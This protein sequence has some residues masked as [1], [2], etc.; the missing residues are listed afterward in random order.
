MSKKEYGYLYFP[1]VMLKDILERKQEALKEI[2][3]FNTKEYKTPKG[4][5][6]CSLHPTIYNSFV[7]ESKKESDWVELI[8]FLAIRSILGS[9]EHKYVFTN[10][11]HILSRMLGFDSYTSLASK[12]N[13]LTDKQKQLIKR[14][15]KPNQYEI[16]THKMKRL[17][18][19]LELKWRVLTYS[20]FSRGLFISLEGR[21]T[22]EELS[23]AC[24]NRRE[25]NKIKEL[26]QRKKE[27]YSAYKNT[28]NPELRNNEFE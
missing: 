23:A 6:S 26:Q 20:R 15:T 7:N 21:A 28:I 1:A 9:K 5:S 13:D 11:K 10:N 19:R 8:A 2:K 16:C 25:K 24:E 27:A 3:A 4:S 17:F 22:Y 12:S 18:N 14:F